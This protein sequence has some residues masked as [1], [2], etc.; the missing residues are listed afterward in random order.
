MLV[1][2]HTAKER[3]TERKGSLEVLGYNRFFTHTAVLLLKVPSADICLNLERIYP[4]M[5][6][7][8][9]TK[10]NTPAS[11]PAYDEGRCYAMLFYKEGYTS[12]INHITSSNYG[13]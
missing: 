1:G 11:R 2:V 7:M 3:G 8:M 4:W 5:M 12:L 10:M 9:I 6:L 13:N